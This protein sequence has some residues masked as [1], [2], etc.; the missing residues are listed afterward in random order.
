VGSTVTFT[1]KVT[2]SS[3]TGTMQFTADGGALCTVSLSGG[4]APCATSGLS[5]GTHNI[6]AA[7]GGD[8]N[9]AS[10]TSSTL[11]ESI[12][13]SSAPLAVTITS[14][15]NGATVSGVVTVSA[16]A[17]DGAAITSMT[18][19]IDGAKVAT[20]NLAS[21]SYKWNTKK[22]AKGSHTIS[23]TAK[24]SASNQLTKSISVTK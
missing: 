20:T 10:S 22:A 24:D 1:A 4:S 16:K 7:Y 13:S 9:N 11:S 12:T 21:V 3:P 18:L 17:T 6:V 23:A 19:S 8:A 2:G 5:A 15:A 14:P